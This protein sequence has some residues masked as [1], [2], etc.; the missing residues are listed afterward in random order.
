M[1]TLQSVPRPAAS[2]RTGSADRPA[3]V[4]LTAAIGPLVA[5]Y[6][7]IAAL[8]ALITATAPGATLSTGGVLRAAGPAWL[9]VHHVPVSIAGHELGVLPLLPTIGV[10]ALVARSAGNAARRLAWDT[11]RGAA[12]V[13]GT[14]GG[15]HGLF[16][17]LIALL[18]LGWTVTA[19]PV[20][21]FFGAGILAAAAAAVGTA[22]Q[23]GLLAAVLSRADGATETGLRAGRL[24]VVALAGV[25]ALVFAIGVVGSFPT[26]VRLFGAAAPGAG[27]GLGMALLCLAYLP[28]V[29]IGALSFAAGPGFSVG[30]FGLAQWRFHDGALPAVPVLG[31]LPDA[32]ADWWVFLMLLPVAV[33]V[34]VGLVCRR[35]DG[36]LTDRLRAVGVAAL[37]TGGVSLVAAALAGGALADGPFD[38]V[39]V[40]AGS[41][42]VA[43]CLLV[44]VPAAVTVWVT[45][46]TAVLIEDEFEDEDEDEDEPE[47][48]PSPA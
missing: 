42:G 10:L 31:P 2:G 3:R 20:V 41:L 5:G 7:G 23:C 45:G 48:G 18:C 14:V 21:A 4:L 29:L 8:L 22:R 37:V 15:A 6:A 35:F 27:G 13:I 40:P 9:A 19:A 36:R 1:P 24:A 12:K 43:V 11:P 32:V 26:V 44:G 30:S 39:T 33:G 38:P 46:R 47:S 25:G 17:L 34:L 28:N 16:G